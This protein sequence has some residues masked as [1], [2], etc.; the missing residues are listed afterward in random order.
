MPK[1]RGRRYTDRQRARILVAIEQNRM[2]QVA[3]AKKYG[4]STVTIW[5]WRRAAARP[6]QGARRKAAAPALSNGALAELLRAQVRDR[7]RELI[8]DVVRQEVASYLA[9][10]THSRK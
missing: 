4:V 8:P 1:K 6:R 7:L 9:A 10:S 5:A 2:T 3:A